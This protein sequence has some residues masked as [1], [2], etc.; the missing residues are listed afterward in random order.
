MQNN[1][2]NF[3]GVNLWTCSIGMVSQV[4]L[5]Q[6]DSNAHGAAWILC[7]GKI[8]NSGRL[9]NVFPPNFQIV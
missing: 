6:K 4:D 9:A 1:L 2:E 3:H 7:E 5:W 8:R